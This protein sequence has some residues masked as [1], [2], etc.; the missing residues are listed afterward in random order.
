MASERLSGM[1]LHAIAD[2]LNTDGVSTAHGASCWW[3]RHRG[4]GARELV[5]SRLESGVTA[6]LLHYAA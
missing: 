3:S 5:S 6:K 4:R 1:S 2:G